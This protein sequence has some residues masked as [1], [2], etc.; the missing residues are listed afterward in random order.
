MSIANHKIGL[1]KIAALLM[2]STGV[3]NSTQDID[4][5]GHRVVHGGASF[6]NPVHVDEMVEKSQLFSWHTSTIQRTWNSRRFSYF[7]S[8]KQMAVFDTAFHQ[9]IPVIA[10]KYAI[11]INF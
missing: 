1:E 3:I 5:V 2:D 11:L 10:H 7:T 9:T 6:S 4:V 8:A